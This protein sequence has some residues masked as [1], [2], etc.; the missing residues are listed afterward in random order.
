VCE[1]EAAGAVGGGGLR[2]EIPVEEDEIDRGKI[3]ASKKPLEQ[4]ELAGS[5]GDR[6]W[7]GPPAGPGIE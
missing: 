3:L 4:Y 6:L 7:A 1:Q 5:G 2:E